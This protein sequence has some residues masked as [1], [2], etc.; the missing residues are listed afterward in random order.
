MNK[1]STSKA[2][3]RSFRLYKWLIALVIIIVLAV[4]VKKRWRAWFVNKPEM[5]YT[6][7]DSIDRVTL[8]SGED[9]LSQ[10]TIS[11]R[12]G[13]ELQ[14]ASLDLC[15]WTKVDT[16]LAYD[17]FNWKKIKA[18]GVLVHSRSGKGCFY[19]V[20][21]D[22]L[23]AGHQY[24]YT[25]QTGNSQSKVFTFKIP[26]GL[27]SLERFLYLGDVQDPTG[28]LSKKL[29]AN[30]LPKP[31][32][33]QEVDT[34]SLIKAP[35]HFVAT[36]GDQIEGPSDAYWNVWYQSWGEDYTAQIPFNCATGNHEY[37]KK[38]LSRELDPRWVVQYNYPQN[39]VEGFQGRSYYIDYPLMRFIVLDSNGITLP[40]E[41]MAHR[42]W[43]K[44][45]LSSSK[46]PWQVV[47]FHHGVECVREGRSNPIMKYGFKSILEDYGADLVLQGHDHAYSRITSKS[48]KGEE[49]TPVYVIS[50]SSP[51]LYR[52][53]FD[54]VHDRL[55]SGVQLYQLIEVRPEILSYKSY[56]YSGQLYDKLVIDR[57]KLLDNRY[58]VIDE[59]KGL[60]E[61]FE[62]NAFGT[63]K[64]ALK[65]AQKYQEAI[66]ERQR[67][68]K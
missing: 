3:K 45:L 58:R 54:A 32:L 55:A 40:S 44:E 7:P 24:V 21:L 57:T 16:T 68:L 52:N 12:C 17:D 8:T 14:E 67:Q 19:S 66:K 23:Q 60:P 11:W 18:E 51:K 61:V 49:L 26:K 59:A 27:D 34:S 5:A 47:M 53:A 28:E 56:L 4:I 48:D 13:E 2:K 36:A 63:S 46:Q 62:F 64:K 41:I 9:F 15:D 43:L 37:L 42:D 38:G 39:S 20:R 6:T 35:I 22:S 30:L 50:T 1:V 33:E 65:K 31:S 10:R 29:F 25:I